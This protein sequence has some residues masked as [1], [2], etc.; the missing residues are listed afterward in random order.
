M[1]NHRQTFFL[2]E[3][4]E[5]RNQISQKQGLMKE[6]VESISWTAVAIPNGFNDLRLTGGVKLT[7]IKKSNACILEY[8]GEKENI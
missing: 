8:S 1:T 6:D 4:L 7:L 5:Y 3:E 2:P